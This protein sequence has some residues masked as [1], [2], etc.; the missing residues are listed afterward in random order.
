VE[1]DIVGCALRNESTEDT[2]F[3]SHDHSHAP[4]RPLASEVDS[5]M[6]QEGRRRLDCITG[7]EWIRGMA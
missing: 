3:L 2:T 7:A 6:L 5:L 1:C 4:D